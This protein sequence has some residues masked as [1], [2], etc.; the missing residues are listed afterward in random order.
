MFF[1]VE[2]GM[3]ELKEKRSGEIDRLIGGREFKTD[4]HV[5]KDEPSVSQILLLQ[6]SILPC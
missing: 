1:A 3:G 4:R 6:A 5:R 2:R